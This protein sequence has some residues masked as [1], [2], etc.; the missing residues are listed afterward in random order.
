MFVESVAALL[1]NGV[2]RALD[3][4]EGR[5]PDTTAR[6][7][8]APAWFLTALKIKSRIEG[9]SS[10]S[11][12]TKSVLPQEIFSRNPALSPGMLSSGAPGA[13]LCPEGRLA[14]ATTR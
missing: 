9:G 10:F 11:L 6:P 7:V 12:R 13:G 5:K 8:C 4:R 1:L 3:P 2:E 14:A